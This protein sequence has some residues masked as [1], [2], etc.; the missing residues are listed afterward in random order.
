MSSAIQA[1]IYDKLNTDLSTPVFDYVAQGADSGSDTPFPYIAIGEDTLNEFDTDTELGADGTLTIHTWSR[2]KGR[3][4]CKD[5]Q[6]TIYD[7]LNRAAIT[8]T[9][10][11]LIDVFW[12]SD[13]SFY[14]ED[15]ETRH[16][17]SLYRILIDET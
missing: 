16:G 13:Q 7:S 6:G 15:G 2:A 10:Y 3:K 4:E 12:I 11:N 9:G 8:V 17:V 5:I 1:A 14:D